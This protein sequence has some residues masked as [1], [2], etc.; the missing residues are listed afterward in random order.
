[1]MDAFGK[2]YNGYDDLEGTILARMKSGATQELV[3]GALK[4][5]FA[6]ALANQ[7]VIIDRPKRKRLF[8][9]VS[10]ALLE[11]IADELDSDSD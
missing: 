6:A 1:M 3:L 8:G 5:G 4:N 10:R 9:R 11:E 7:T 2:P